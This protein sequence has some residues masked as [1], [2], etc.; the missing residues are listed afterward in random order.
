L[1]E[2]G[3]EKSYTKLIGAGIQEQKFTISVP[4]TAKIE[5]EALVIECLSIEGN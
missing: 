5:N 3:V 2:N 4:E 1:E